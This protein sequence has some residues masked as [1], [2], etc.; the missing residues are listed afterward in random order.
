MSILLG[1]L[2]PQGGDAQDGK[3]Q[4]PRAVG[5]ATSEL[6]FSSLTET[7]AHLLILTTLFQ[8]L[9]TAM[10]PVILPNLSIST[11]NRSKLMPETQII[12]AI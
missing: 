8:M 7:V 1:H 4:L 9:E 11:G 6:T 3:S 5:L 10:K 2:V 12:V